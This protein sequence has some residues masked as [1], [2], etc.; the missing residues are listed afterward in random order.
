MTPAPLYA[1]DRLRV[2]SPP[3]AN[4]GDSRPRFRLGQAPGPAAKALW[5]RA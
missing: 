1:L 2:P 4:P 5:T 3:A